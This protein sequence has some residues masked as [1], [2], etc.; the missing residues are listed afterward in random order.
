M[1]AA[2]QS[3]LVMATSLAVRV[4]F[5]VHN[6]HVSCESVVARECLLFA[7]VRASDFHLAVVVDGVLVPCQVVRS[8][9]DGVARL[10]GRRIDAGAF[11]RPRL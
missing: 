3:K 1:Q 10:A 7:A 6:T 8:G 11:V 9:E 5:R 4:S 2:S